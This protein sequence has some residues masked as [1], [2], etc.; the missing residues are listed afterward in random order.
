MNPVCLILQDR[1][2]REFWLRQFSN[3]DEENYKESPFYQHDFNLFHV[4]RSY[5]EWLYLTAWAVHSYAW[6]KRLEI[7]FR[8][9]A[10]PLSLP[11]DNLVKILRELIRIVEEIK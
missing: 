3:Y 2:S 11:V 8:K 7:E 1:E 4:E 6:N 5:N 9:V 10:H